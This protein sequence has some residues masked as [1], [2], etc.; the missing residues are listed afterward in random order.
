EKL[1]GPATSRFPIL[2]D[3][4]SQ[5]FTDYLAFVVAFGADE[6]RIEEVSGVVISFATRRPGGFAPD[7]VESLRWLASPLG[8]TL[9]ADINRQIAW[10]ALRTF[11][12]ATV[13]ARI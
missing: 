6:P 11:H 10:S 5:G 4:A 12:G 9:Q 13:G 2:A 7:G 8:L 1:D 3:L